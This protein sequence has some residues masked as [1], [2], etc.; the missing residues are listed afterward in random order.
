MTQSRQQGW[1]HSIENISA[2]SA[3]ICCTLCGAPSAITRQ[4]ATGGAGPVHASTYT[5]SGFAEEAAT[6]FASAASGK[7]KAAPIRRID[8]D[9]DFV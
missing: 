1:V 4:L 6:A 7:P 5:Y 8:G 3:G 2:S 9:D